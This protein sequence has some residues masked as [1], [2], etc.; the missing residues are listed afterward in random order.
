MNKY[1]EDINIRRDLKLFEQD[2]NFVN[3]ITKKR[4]VEEQFLNYEL[5]KRSGSKSGKDLLI[6][7]P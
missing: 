5:R 1:K 3:N 6:I 7:L 4:F 2:F